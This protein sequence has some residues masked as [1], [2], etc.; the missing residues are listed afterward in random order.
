MNKTEKIDLP[1]AGKGVRNLKL[2]DQLPNCEIIINKNLYNL[3]ELV[4]NKRVIDIGCGYGRNKIIVEKNGGSWVGVDLIAKQSNVVVGSAEKLPFD[5]CSF[6]VVIM[7]AV[8]EHIPNVSKAFEEVSRVLKP[9]GIFIG[10]VAFMESYHEISYSHLSFKALEYYA[11]KYNMKLNKISGGSAFGID[12]HLAVLLYPSPTKYLR[13]IVSFLIRSIT[14]L[15]SK[16]SYLYLRILRKE[17]K[18][19]SKELAVK[20]YQLECLKMSS[21]FSFIIKK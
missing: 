18:I 2:K 6:D 9:N 17:T 10:Y 5:E 19:K 1:P 3:A 12:Y 21:G 7:D 15:K 8:L 11:D 20:Y 14:L 4:K 16:L 13:R